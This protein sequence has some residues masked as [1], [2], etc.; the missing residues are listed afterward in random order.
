M[1]IEELILNYDFEGVSKQYYKEYGYNT[2]IET[3]LSILKKSANN[4]TLNE[5]NF[6]TALV[7]SLDSYIFSDFYNIEKTMYK[8]C[9]DKNNFFENISQYLSHNYCSFKWNTIT[10]IGRFS[11]R[12]NIKYLEEVYLSLYRNNNPVIA[13]VCLNELG[14]LKSNNYSLFIDELENNNTL[15]NIITLCQHFENI[16]WKRY[17]VKILYNKCKEI[18]RKLFLSYEY[19]IFS[20]MVSNFSTFSRNI[21]YHNKLNDWNK[22]EYEKILEYYIENYQ[23]I[24]TEKDY[25]NLYNK[26]I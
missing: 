14:W 8:K 24:N 25:I 10:T 18:F 20:N 11:I 6:Y 13:Y 4:I 22:N 1:N 26:I 23:E 7:F 21:Q 5:E 17:K 12:K 2:I 3:I 15:I 19:D 16:Q 9:L